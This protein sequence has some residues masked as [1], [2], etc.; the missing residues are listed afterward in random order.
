LREGKYDKLD[1]DGLISPGT[2]VHG[3]DII[4]GKI[5]EQQ[6]DTYTGGVRN[7][8]QKIM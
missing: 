4:I 3:D 8:G 2:L 6:N 1:L 7:I 5:R